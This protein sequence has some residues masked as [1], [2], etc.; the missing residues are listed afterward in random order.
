MV[1]MSALKKTT[2]EEW[3]GVFVGVRTQP[4]IYRSSALGW[5]FFS[6]V[7]HDLYERQQLLVKYISKGEVSIEQRKFNLQDQF[8]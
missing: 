5:P 7:N 4:H 1:I 8:L 6:G 3:G 2:L